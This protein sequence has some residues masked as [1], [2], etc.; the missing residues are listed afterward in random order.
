M[1]DR[2]LSGFYAGVA[3]GALMNVIALVAHYALKVSEATYVDWAAL[4]IYGHKATSLGQ[5][6]YAL[7][8]HLLWS[9]FLGVA[10]AY[11]ISVV[12]SRHL[13]FKAWL[14]SVIFWFATDTV[15]SLM[16]RS[17]FATTGLGTSVMYFL[18]ASAFGLLV[19]YLLPRLENPVRSR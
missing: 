1:Q 9:G 17:P 7:L 13:L 3:G 11:F 6:A 5:T 4:M 16:E 10:L 14:F 2:F 15:T 18:G 8:I 19:G 12:T